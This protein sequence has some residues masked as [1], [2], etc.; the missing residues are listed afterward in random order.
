M[1]KITEN[2]LESLALG[3]AILGSGGGGSPYLDVLVTREQIGRHGPITLL[4]VDELHYDDLVVPVAFMGA[5]LV[6]LEK[7][8]S[9]KEFQA[10]FNSI[11]RFF[12]RKPTAIMP[13]EI[14]GSNAFTPLTIAGMLQ[15]PVLDADSIGRAFPEVHMSSFNIHGIVAT[16]AFLSDE[17]GNTVTLETDS[18]LT[19]EHLARQITIAFGSNAALAAY[20]MTG[21]QAQKAA[22]RGSITRAINLGNA[23]QHTKTPIENLL[24]TTQ[25]KLLAQGTIKHVD[26]TVERGFLMGT[27]TIVD[28]D[29]NQALVSYQNENLIVTINGN[30][31]ATTPDVIAILDTTTGRAITTEMLTYGL[32]VS[33]V[34]FC[35]DPLWTTEKGLALT[36]PR[37]FGYD[38]D[39]ISAL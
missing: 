7:L 14:G 35:S 4:S 11:E 26:Q 38:T 28:R 20:I 30:I 23:I 8:P 25:G 27:T 21:A 2:M 18:A 39:Y 3:S 33:I 22:I 31:M 36:G 6:A 24:R 12:G 34:T 32:Q 9:G 1:Q 29:N 16:P 5:P 17:H 19:M 13:A 15:V 37:Y 10:I